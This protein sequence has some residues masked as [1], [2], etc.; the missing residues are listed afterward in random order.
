MLA[1]SFGQWENFW[2]S[3]EARQE[4]QD[5]DISGGAAAKMEQVSANEEWPSQPWWGWMQE[6]LQHSILHAHRDWKDVREGIWKTIS[7]YSCI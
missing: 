4:F 5:T 2:A 1:R 3:Q 7:F 6:P